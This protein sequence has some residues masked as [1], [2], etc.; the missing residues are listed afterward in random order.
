MIT[1]FTASLEYVEKQSKVGNAL[2][3]VE[4]QSTLIQ[5][6]KV[7]DRLMNQLKKFIVDNEIPTKLV[8]TNIPKIVNSTQYFDTIQKG[9]FTKVMTY[10]DLFIFILNEIF[11]FL[12]S[13]IGI[14]V[15]EIFQCLS[16]QPYSTNEIPY[17]TTC[18][19]FEC[20]DPEKVKEYFEPSIEYSNSIDSKCLTAPPL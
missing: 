2:N 17:I 18:F 15:C 14:S 10:E 7:W 20:H 6:L 11:N 9:S 3:Y 12:N 8:K 19:N 13:I 1:T 4:I 5:R 16:S